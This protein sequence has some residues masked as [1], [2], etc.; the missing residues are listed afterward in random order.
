MKEQEMRMNLDI[1]N[2][3]NNISSMDTYQ[4]DP[5]RKKQ[6]EVIEKS[7]NPS[8]YSTIEQV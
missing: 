4:L 5:Y 3:N 7:L 6:L 8:R 2:Q 1:L